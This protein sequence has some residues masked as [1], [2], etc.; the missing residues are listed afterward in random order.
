MGENRRLDGIP[1]VHFDLTIFDLSQ[2]LLV[3]FQVHGLGQAIS[4]GFEHK[5]VVR[6]LDV[7][8]RSVVLASYLG[9]ENGCQ[10]V[11]GP[12]SQQR[13]G[14][15]LTTSEPEQ[16]QGACSVPPPTGAEHG[17]LQHR[18]EQ[19][20]LHRP[21]GKVGE[22]LVQGERQV[23]SNGKVQPVV[24]GRRL[25]LEIEGTADAFAQRHAPSPVDPGAEGCV[26][27]QLHTTAF[28][29]EALS[30]NPAGGGHHPQDSFSFRHVGDHL[31][32][33]LP[34]DPGLRDHPGF[35]FNR[36]FQ[37]LVDPLAQIADLLGQ[38]PG[39][40]GSF[41]QPEGDGGGQP[42]GIL[43]PHPAPL[44]PAYL[45]GGVAQ[46][47]NVSGHAFDGEVLVDCAHEDL[48]GVSYDVVVGVVGN[49]AAVGQS[50]QP[51]APAAP[52][53][54]VDAIPVQVGPG[55]PLP[56][57]ESMG[58]RLQYLVE[59]FPGQVPVGV[60]P[61]A[62]VKE[63]VFGPLLGGAARHNLLGQHV[64]WPNGNFQ[65]VQVAPAYSTGQGRALHQF[66]PCQGKEPA[67]GCSSHGMARTSDA[68]QQQA[69]GARGPYLADQVHHPDVYPQLQGGGGHADFDLA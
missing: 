39:P 52:Q 37:P 2:D 10:Q 35:G 40:A 48:F 23:G 44:H 25:K 16:R 8:G 56:G 12:H 41:A 33:R 29:E 14:H 60:S 6:G 49:G 13:G 27:H 3:S 20:L 11:V 32:G 7:T 28:V 5:R 57:S 68:L 21:G 53:Y 62:H 42:L 17:R 1:C 58:Q 47:E 4:N 18:L 19:H 45:P 51:G 61:A 22:H 64:Q 31:S 38:L 9:R 65:G 34:R 43:D 66:V 46:E 54:S 59:L 36:V 69:N 63:V 50:C 26:N 30:H 15:L 24:G 67:L 55:P